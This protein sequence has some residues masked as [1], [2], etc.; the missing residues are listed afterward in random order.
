[1]NIHLNNRTLNENLI[2]IKII[3]NNFNYLALSRIQINY[4]GIDTKYKL[5]VY[6]VIF[7][8]TRM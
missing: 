8:P 7:K 4:N 2:T 6:K 1:M 3:D 5:L